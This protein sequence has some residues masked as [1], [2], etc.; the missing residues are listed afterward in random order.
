MSKGGAIFQAFP[1]L[2]VCVNMPG[3]LD[4]RDLKVN[5]KDDLEN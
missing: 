2:C 4:R 3:S 1:N 5:S